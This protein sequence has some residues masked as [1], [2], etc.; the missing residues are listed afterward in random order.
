MQTDLASEGDDHEELFVCAAFQL[1][2][3]VQ[4]LRPCL[5]TDS[6]PAVGFIFVERDEFAEVDLCVKDVLERGCYVVGMVVT[7]A[8][9]VVMFIVAV[10]VVV[11]HVGGTLGL[12]WLWMVGAG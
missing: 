9:M 7:V 4:T 6:A 2:F 3:E 8:A 1:G 5:L 11:G 12:W 10:G